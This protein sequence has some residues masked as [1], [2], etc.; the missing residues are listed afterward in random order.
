LGDWLVSSS[1]YEKSWTKKHFLEI[2]YVQ[3]TNRINIEIALC[4]VSNEPYF[5]KFPQIA[6][7]LFIREQMEFSAC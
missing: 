7:E 2:L 6:K 4:K 5:T 1:D 3:I